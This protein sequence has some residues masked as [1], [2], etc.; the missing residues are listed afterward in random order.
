MVR[1]AKRSQSGMYTIRAVN[2]HGEDECDVEMVVLGPPERPEGPMEISDVHKEGCK[3]KWKEPLDDGGS[4][5][6]GY[7][8]EKM[9]TAT[10]R[11][12]QC[13]KTDGALEADVKGLETGKRYRFR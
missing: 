3:I 5:I 2:E 4:P 8:L 1:N 6:T 10:G 12:T 9:D 13:A 7:V 11:W